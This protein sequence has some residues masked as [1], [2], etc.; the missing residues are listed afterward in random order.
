[1][2]GRLGKAKKVTDLNFAEAIAFFGDQFQQ[3]EELL[4]NVQEA[5]A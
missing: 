2:R 4:R 3:E 1:M 5:S